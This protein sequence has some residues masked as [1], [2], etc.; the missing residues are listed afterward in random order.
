MDVKHQHTAA[1]IALEAT[2]GCD[3]EV[4]LWT[5]SE[6][7][8]MSLFRVS[9]SGGG[10]TAHT[11]KLGTY[12]MHED[13][14]GSLLL[15]KDPDQLRFRLKGVAAAGRGS[16]KS[17]SGG[18]VDTGRFEVGDRVEAE[19]GDED[20]GW[21]PGAI[22]GK[23]WEEEEDDGRSTTAGGRWLYAIAYDDG[24]AEDDVE[25][26][27]IAF[28]NE[29]STSIRSALPLI[30]TAS[31]DGEVHLVDSELLAM[32]SNKGKSAARLL[33]FRGHTSVV[34][35]MAL[36]SSERHLFTS[37]YD[38]SI[39]VWDAVKGDCLNAFDGGAFGSRCVV[40]CGAMLATICGEVDDGQEDGK[41]DAGSTA[42]H[43]S[44]HVW[45]QKSLPFVNCGAGV[46]AVQKKSRRAIQTPNPSY[47]QKV[48]TAHVM[49]TVPSSESIPAEPRGSCVRDSVDDDDD[50][51]EDYKEDF[52]D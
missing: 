40:A 41:L 44:I 23:K 15:P 16:D 3:G 8:T 35:T 9:F 39:R 24:D 26:A 43:S 45:G 28:H 20:E 17:S 34:S 27:L 38:R 25:E 12:A 6:D 49:G 22:T 31:G 4:V 48:C 42:P 52:D 46:S 10:G 36:S 29:A 14:V 30:F 51:K 5:G 13:T 2:L 21:F 18:S 1:V 37:S 7:G 47:T 11:R 19:F 33:R 50:G 32:A